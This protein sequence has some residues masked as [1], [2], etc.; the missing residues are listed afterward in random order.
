MGEAQSS[1]RGTRGVLTA[2]LVLVTIGSLLAAAR[3]SGL[4][5]DASESAA[6]E[7]G[8]RR[9][10]D[11][12][13]SVAEQARKAA[14]TARATAE[15]ETYHAMLSEVKALRAGHQLGWRDEA[16]GNLA[17]LATMPTPRRDL[18]ELRTEAVACLGE[19]DVVEAARLEGFRRGVWS[20]EFSP[21]S[22]A[23]ATAASNGD[24][25]L[26]GVSSR[27]FSWQV[28]D[29][30]GQRSPTT[31]PT[32]GDPLIHVRFLPD[33]SLVRTTWRHC[34]EFLDASGEPSARAPIVG[35]EAQP[36]G[37]EIDRQGR[38]LAVG[39]GDG[40]IELHDLATGTL[41]RTIQGDPRT[42]ALSPD[43]RWLALAGPNNRVQIQ[44]TDDGGPPVRLGAHQA[45]ITSLVFSRD[46][47]TLASTSWD[48]TATLWNVAGREERVTL[49]GHKERV[50]DLAFSPDGNWVATT[51]QDY[52]A[53]IWD[54]RTGQTLA[55][56]P[57]SGFMWRVEFSPN[58]QYLAVGESNR[59]V[60]L[61]QIRGR[62]ERRLLVG[63]VNGTRT[64]AFHPRLARL[65]SGADD[66]AIIV[67]DTESGRPVRHWSAHE[68][69]VGGLGYS[70][71]GSLL[72]SACGYDGHSDARVW[73]A[74]TGSL[75]RTLP[76]HSAGVYSMA[77]DP[78][79]R[80]VATGDTSGLLIVWDVAT[81]RILRRETVGPSW[82]WSIAFL[83]EGRRLV[84]EVSFGPIVV[85]DLEGTDPPRRVAVPGGMRRFVVDHT[86]NDLIVAGNGGMLTRV[87][88][89]DL[90]VGHHLDKGHEGN[91]ES[92]ALHP[93][94]RLLATGGLTDRRIILRD[95]ETFEPLLI[96]P[97]WTGKVRDLAFDSSGRWLAIAGADSDVG[98]WDL[99][100]VRDELAALGL[101]WDQP[102]P[103]VVSTTDL[104]PARERTRPPV[105][106]I[107]PGK[108][109]GAEFEK[110]N[111]LDRAGLAAIEQG[112]FAD[113]T[114]A[115]QEASDRFQSLRRS[116][117][118]DLQLARLHA[119]S[120]GFLAVSLH[121]QKQPAQALAHARESLAV[122][123]RMNPPNPGDLYNMARACALVSAL[124]DQGSPEE[125]EKFATRA[126]EY[127][128]RA[129][130][131]DQPGIRPL[132][133]SNRDLDP[134]RT[135]AD[136]QDMMTDAGFPRDPFAQPSPLAFFETLSSSEQQ[137]LAT[138]SQAIEHEP[139]SF[140]GW[141]ARGNFF[142]QRGE[143]GSSLT[144]FRKA[145]EIKPVTTWEGSGFNWTGFAM[146][147][148]VVLIKAGDLDGYHRLAR[149]MFEQFAETSNPSVGERTA[150]VILLFPPPKT[151]LNRLER[152]TQLAV[153]QRQDNP[154]IG[155]FQMARGMAAYRSGDFVKAGEWLQ[156]ASKGNNG[157]DHA[158][159]CKSYLAMTEFRL[160]HA[161]HARFLL[162]EA[163][164]LN[165]PRTAVTKMGATWSDIWI[166]EI[167]HR[168]AEALINP[169][170]SPA[171]EPA[172]P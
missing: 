18:V 70:P 95:A 46:G 90:A 61:Y 79:G 109:D 43:G 4:A 19:T 147:A 92:L 31:W 56:L 44:T 57:G 14:E 143:W 80:R 28:V 6:A 105:A 48:Q 42:F 112:R 99:G 34:V 38:L 102:A 69:F 9:E 149:S 73:D 168:E 67:W 29:P 13:R 104:A 166:A 39:W 151:E 122:Y 106:V 27:Q 49:R 132:V 124:N 148:A 60:R 3:F 68:A 35:G 107:R 162:L 128:R 37:L 119:M 108:I 86:R 54:A 51:S 140:E 110:A 164:K 171:I 65:A 26:W 87:S 47:A 36:V 93:G 158:C 116:S 53:R 41:R 155:W 114:A 127:L 66:H 32:A 130:E 135:R 96:L 169:P 165:A 167:A 150:K 117:P 72:V 12:A 1:D 115:F 138:L 144:D 146:R 161:D 17:R 97:I 136:F 40:R 78:S 152:M 71:D 74:E 52:T 141:Y 170:S 163:G 25:D 156:K 98:L 121:D 24:L 8:A 16:L 63:H 172:R 55:V 137:Q 118:G 7:R 20:L 88:L 82:I 11:Q 134:L 133:G 75:L 111:A 59:F 83:D 45:K 64:L 81:G 94:G 2:V 123:E 154:Y 84:T 33:G 10:A 89:R 126:V 23:L 120:L 145:L 5:E 21:D 58:G 62:R 30:V 142:A 77:F 76:D 159:T 113:A 50:T 131:G 157:P 160:G 129:I 15:G 125:R 91:I 139:A 22:G 85:Y 100:L 103:A 153:D 101:A